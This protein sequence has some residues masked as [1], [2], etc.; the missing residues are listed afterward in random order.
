MG[1]FLWHLYDKN[2]QPQNAEHDAD[3][4]QKENCPWDNRLTNV[5]MTQLKA[6]VT[7]NVSYSWTGLPYR[8][9]LKRAAYNIS[10][11]KEKELSH[12]WIGAAQNWAG[13]E[14]DIQQFLTI[15][16]FRREMLDELR[17]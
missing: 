3:L 13:W 6:W 12:F 4:L 1:A 5:V 15:L 9:M 8:K 2:N 17:K 16:R 11:T 7:D 10:P 14:K